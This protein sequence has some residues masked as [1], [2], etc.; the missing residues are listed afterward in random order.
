MARLIVP[1]AALVHVCRHGLVHNPG[2]VLYSRLPGFHLSEAGRAMAEQLG[3][4]FAEAPVTYLGVSPLERARETMVPIA[5]RHH[6]PVVIDERLIEAE[7]R[8]QGQVK[9]PRSLWLAKPANWRFFVSRDGWGEGFQPMADR[10]TAAIAD[11]GLAAGPGGHAVLVSH[12]SPIW[13]ARRHAEG[14]FLLNIPIMRKCEL[15]SVTTFAVA[16]DGAVSF[17]SYEEVTT[18][19]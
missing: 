18:T 19:K 6:V 16:P 11:A 15:A 2:N 9:G 10:T 17:V 14:K 8:M 1:D 7:S 12:Q 5:A 13:A 3:Q 4:F